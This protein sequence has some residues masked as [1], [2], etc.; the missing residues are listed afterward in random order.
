V[1]GTQTSNTTQNS[2][3]N[4]IL[5]KQNR[6]S[7]LI[8]GLSAALI[9][10]GGGSSGG[11][12][13]TSPEP[14]GEI[15][16]TAFIGTVESG[17]VN[18]YAL[19]NGVRGESIGTGVIRS[20]PISDLPADIDKLQGNYTISLQTPSKAIV[21]CL[22]D[23]TY[24]EM[25]ADRLISFIVA[26]NQELCAVVNY[27]TGSKTLKVVL[28]YYT[29]V[30]A[31]LAQYLVSNGQIPADAV[32]K[33]NQEISDWT[34]LN[35]TVVVPTNIRYEPSVAQ[36]SISAADR[37]GLA[38]AAISIYTGWVNGIAGIPPKDAAGADNPKRFVIYNSILFAQRAY[39]DIS[40]DGLLDGQSADGPTGLGPVTMKIST[41][42]RD[43]ALDMLVMSNSPKNRS[44]LS[45]L[46]SNFSQGL[47]DYSKVYSEFDHP[48]APATRK[49]SVLNIFGSK[50]IGGV[51]NGIKPILNNFIIPKIIMGDSVFASS[52]TDVKNE[53]IS[54]EY[55]IFAPAIGAALEVNDPVALFI[56]G[57]GV[58]LNR[59]K[60]VFV[61]TITSAAGVIPVVYKYSDRTDYELRV[62]VKYI[63]SANGNAIVT[64]PIPAN[65]KFSIRNV[66]TEIVGPNPVTNAATITGIFNLVS[67]VTNPF[68]INSINLDIDTVASGIVVS[69]F[70]V[71]SKTNVPIFRIDSTTLT[72]GS[73]DFVVRVV[74][75]NGV[76]TVSTVLSLMVSN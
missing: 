14:I 70:T 23:A 15:N 43:I 8:A 63:D 45:L 40:A 66:G 60:A 5:K 26:E 6:Y 46:D 19:N 75:I 59:T 21:V 71:A 24:Q 73:H 52:L 51:I 47:L 36:Q 7:V 64:L 67:S 44:G 10:C 74:D 20:E 27:V 4:L 25:S 35:P 34:V 3:L 49:P 53:A 28:T 76:E 13:P 56:K 50:S 54:V 58:K 12:L 18:V 72:N 11:S 68:G 69:N 31:G 17:T 61:N 30:A 48:D 37:A 16:G 29:H 42:R 2:F 55:R 32:T 65:K 9:S 57:T 33:A 22:S 41:Y 62:I 1:Q 39:E 38:N